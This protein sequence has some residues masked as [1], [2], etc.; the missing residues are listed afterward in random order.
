MCRYGLV[1]LS[2]LLLPAC[3]T[4][5]DKPPISVVYEQY[6]YTPRHLGSN[7]LAFQH[8]FLSIVLFILLIILVQYFNNQRRAYFYYSIYLLIAWLYFARAFPSYFYFLFTDVEFFIKTHNFFI[9]KRGEGLSHQTELIFFFLLIS[10]YLFFVNAFFNMKQDQNATSKQI[11]FIARILLYAAIAMIVVLITTGAYATGAP[12]LIFKHL[13]LLPILWLIPKI[14]RLKLPCGELIIAGSS[15]L[16]IGSMVVGI[17][18]LTGDRLGGKRIYLQM[19]VF[20]EIICFTAALG[21]MNR[22][23]AKEKAHSESVLLKDTP[24]ENTLNQPKDKLLV[25]L[26]ALI[27]Q[28]LERLKN[29][30]DN[31]KFNVADFAHQLFLSPSTLLRKVKAKALVSVEEYVLNY[32]LNRAHEMVVRSENSFTKIA[33]L[34]GFSDQAAFSNAF[35]KKFGCTPSYLRK[36]RNPPF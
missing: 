31:I 21:R 2:S 30:E 12:L 36:N 19:G 8:S 4:I 25:D 32:R 14:I 24:H 13:C 35:K 29:G 7:F 33:E 18:Y 15:M 9:P 6:F 11:L 34:T 22:L 17:L 20:L 27:E 26:D 5:Q 1:F 16:I 3:T 28:A 23:P 10:S